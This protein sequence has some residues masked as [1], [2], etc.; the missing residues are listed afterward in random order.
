V[1]T[2][3]NTRAMGSSAWAALPATTRSEINEEGTGRGA[4]GAAAAGPQPANGPGRLGAGSSCRRWWCGR[5]SAGFTTDSRAIGRVDGR[6]P[7]NRCCILVERSITPGDSSPAQ[8]VFC[9]AA[10]KVLNGQRSELVPRTATVRGAGRL[11]TSRR[12]PVEQRHQSFSNRLRKECLNRI[13]IPVRGP[14]DQRLQGRAQPPTP[15][16]ARAA[17]RPS[18]LPIQPPHY[19]S[20]GD[21]LNPQLQPR[22]LD[23]VIEN[24]YRGL[25]STSRSSPSAFGCQC[26]G[27]QRGKFVM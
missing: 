23:N 5:Y 9:M 14:G 26:T 8:K 24:Q 12:V 2:P 1:P 25:A 27:L 16:L 22:R 7:V 19:A 6:P 13:W 20:P 3:P 18:T 4:R 21:Q 11:S 17:N 10:Y 15:A